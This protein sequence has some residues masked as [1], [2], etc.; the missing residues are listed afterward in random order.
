MLERGRYEARSGRKA[1]VPTGAILV[2]L[3]LLLLLAPSILPSQSAPSPTA[4]L[5]REAAVPSVGVRAAI[6]GEPSEAPNFQGAYVVD[7]GE[8]FVYLGYAGFANLWSGVGVNG[9]EVFADG[10]YLLAFNLAPVPVSLSL[11]THEKGY[12]WSNESVPI[13]VGSS[14]GV[15]IPLEQN[16]AWT[17]IRVVMSGTAW[18]GF[19]AT[20]VSLLPLTDWNLG[21]VDLL[22]MVCLSEAI[23]GFSFLTW[24]A[25]RCMKRA[26]WAPKFSL[27]VWGHVFLLT[28]FVTVI[29]D[30]QF[31][32]QTFAGWSPVVYIAPLLPMWFAFALSL[33]NR[34]T[35]RECLQIAS[36]PNQR[37]M[38]GRYLLRL[39]KNLRGEIVLIKETWAQFWARLFGHYVVLTPKDISKPPALVV[40]VVNLASPTE[41]GKGKT[42]SKGAFKPKT[43]QWD[44]A[45]I[46][47]D[48]AQ[49]DEVNGISW[50][51]AGATVEVRYPHLTAHKTVHV[52]EQTVTRRNGD[53]RT[54]PAHDE[55]RWSWPHYVE[56]S[57]ETLPLHDIHYLNAVAASALMLTAEDLA[58]VIG[59]LKTALYMLRSKHETTVS[60]EVD[61]QLSA[62]LSL[63]GFTPNDITE[64]QAAGA[65]VKRRDEPNRS[66]RP[67]G[68]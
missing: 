54:I 61:A 16:A 27:I 44:A 13:G 65:A 36:L 35:K 32:D 66:P 7:H 24:L 62:Y 30:Y 53:V 37:L 9:S 17:S 58:Q 1:R 6:V 8:I 20:P 43:L 39:G 23:I 34:T 18:F 59:S 4:V 49:D 19:V 47:N 26:L 28:T 46:V 25:W 41:T 57:A 50:V 55:Q 67:Q 15:P 10:L 60:A 33:F 48:A 3:A 31:I 5:A 11:D 21:G 51:K 68:E 38:I 52:D 45:P 63:L 64:E 40:P 14:V 29:A 22:V 56:G 42:R 2:G 12:G